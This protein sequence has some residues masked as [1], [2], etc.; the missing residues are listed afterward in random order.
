MLFMAALAAAKRDPK[1]RAFHERLIANGKKPIVA[2]T[3][4]MR[5]LVIICNAM[6]RPTAVAA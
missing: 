4:V 5:K 6:S 3:A 2:I 1:M